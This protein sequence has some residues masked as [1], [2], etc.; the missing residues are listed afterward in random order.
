MSLKKSIVSILGNGLST[1]S[2]LEESG[3]ITAIENFYLI[4]PNS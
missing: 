4:F 3:S 2:K 1:F